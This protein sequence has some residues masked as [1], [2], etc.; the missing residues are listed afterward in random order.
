MIDKNLIHKWLLTANNRYF[1]ILLIVTICLLNISVYLHTVF[2]ADGHLVEG[3]V[4]REEPTV[5][6][7]RSLKFLVGTRMP[8][9]SSNE[10]QNLKP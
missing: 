3:K 9:V 1:K 6:K 10:G 2:A 7:G 5:N 8:I 4:L